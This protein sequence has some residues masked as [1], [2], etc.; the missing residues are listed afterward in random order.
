MAQ[1]DYVISDQD[2]ASF[3]VDINAQLAAIVSENS[4]A[5]E[6]TTMYAYQLWADTSSGIL[7][8]RNAANN[9][10]INLY[11]L[12]T[13]MPYEARGTV[14]MHAT[15]MDLWAQPNTI[16][17]TGSAVTI[18]AIA[19]APQAGAKRTLY[20]ITGTVIT[21]GAT[22]AVEGGQSYTTEAGDKLEFE[23]IT[24]STYKVH[25]T[26]KNGTAVTS[27]HK[28]ADIDATVAANA[29]TITI[30]PGV[31]DFRSTTLTD[32]TPVSRTLSSPV[33]VVVPDTATLGTVNNIA[34]RLVAV[35]IDNAGTLEA[36]VVN[37]AGGNQLDETNL[38]N[39]TTIS[40]G[41]DSNNVIYSTTGRTGVAYR[42]VGF[43]NITEATAG[44]WAT[45][46]TLVQ[47]CGG[48][49]LTALSSLGYGQ[50]WQNLTGSRS[51]GTTYYN[52]TGKPIKVSVYGTMATTGNYA[53]LSVDGVPVSAHQ[54]AQNGYI[55]SL[56]TIVPPANSY[57]LANGAGTFT[58]TVWAELR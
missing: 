17:G 20:P 27:P 6:P 36:A 57:V 39:T 52:T 4:G 54:V 13:G 53:T 38:I 23:A 28:I 21:N 37:L 51:V 40:T 44:T 45:A 2:G 55:F 29:L 9:A 26:K 33:S 34:A 32:G 14:T 10:W 48:Q 30:N 43:I 22:F 56:E 46:P 16:D 42:I 25:I 58:T 3:L 49:A 7:K 15:T 1:A 50:T 31:W 47:G 12:S 5:T 41:A 18:T 24:T 11:T 8:Q 19:N 35:L